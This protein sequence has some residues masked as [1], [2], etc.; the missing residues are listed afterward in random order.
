MKP[1]NIAIPVLFIALAFIQYY[2]IAL[3]FEQ[4][5]SD[6]S[7]EQT[8][9]TNDRFRQTLA[10]PWVTLDIIG[11]RV[12]QT[13]LIS[14]RGQIIVG[15]LHWTSSTGE[16]V[17]ETSELYG[18]NSYTRQNI[19]AYGDKARTG[20]YLFPTHLEPISYKYW[21]PNFIGLRTATFDHVEVMD[22]EQVYVFN[23]VGTEMD[24]TDGYSGLPDVPE[25]YFA[26][27]DGKGTLWIEPFSGIVVDYREVGNSYFVDRLTKARLANFHEWSA[28][29]TPQT[30][31]AQLELARQARAKIFILE[32]WIPGLLAAMGLVWPVIG[33]LRGRWRRNKLEADLGQIN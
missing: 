11:R 20:Q 26:Y 7:N 3:F 18:V 25:R 29:F 2:W 17:F 32:R 10:D 22:G 24:E 33:T 8:L 16:N 31:T 30:H 15:D 28:Q 6:Y 19:P 4:L 14:G 27:T 23:F 21:D 1:F 12:D 9:D 13:L 5:P